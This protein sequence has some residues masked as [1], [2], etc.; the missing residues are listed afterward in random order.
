[1]THTS[2]EV[3]RIAEG[4]M[5]PEEPISGHVRRSAYDKLLRITLSL[6]LR[7]HLTKGKSNG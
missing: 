5:S 4:I 6:M 2:E 7:D 1:M 3:A